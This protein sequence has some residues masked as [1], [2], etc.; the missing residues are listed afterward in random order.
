MYKSWN[1]STSISYQQNAAE[2][3]TGKYQ[4]EDR[5][6]VCW[7]ISRLLA[8]KRYK[9]LDYK[10]K[11]TAAGSTLA[12]TDCP[13]LCRFQKGRLLCFSQQNMHNHDGHGILSTLS[14]SACLT[15]NKKTLICRQHLIFQRPN[16]KS[17]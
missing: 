13:V 12:P 2:N 17:F 7:Q 15:K 9:R 16:Y 5:S 14:W 11:D 4:E 3:N 6:S 8:R 1:N 10:L